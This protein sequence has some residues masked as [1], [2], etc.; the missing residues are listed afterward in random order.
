MKSSPDQRIL[1]IDDMPSI[2]ED[3]RKVL[4]PQVALDEDEE[5]LFGH[6]A[7]SDTGGNYEL[8]SAYQGREGAALA[9]TAVGAGRPYALAFVDMRMPPG[10]D[11]IETIERLWQIDPRLQVVICTAY[12]DHP[13]E[14][15]LERLDVRDRLLVVKKPFD[16]I[17]VS[18]LARTLTA[19]WQLARQAETQI[20][21]LEQA[22]RERTVALELANR[23]L[24]LHLGV[25]ERMIEELAATTRAAE[26]ANQAK[27]QFLA[28]M[29]HEIRTPMNGVIGLSRLLARTELTTRQRDYSDKIMSSAQHLLGIINDILDFSKVD[30]GML[31]IEQTDF[32]LDGMLENARALLSG[33]SAARNLELVMEVAPDVPPCLVGDSL[34]LNQ[35]LINYA[36]NA[37]KF[38][39]RGRIVISVGVGERSQEDVLLRFAVTDTG[40]GIAPEQIDRLFQSFSQV[41][42]ST[43][44]KFGGTGLGLAICK[45]LAGLMGGEVGVESETGKGSTFWFTARLGIGGAGHRRLNAGVERRAAAPVDPSCS[46]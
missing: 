42:A 37:L 46:V 19:K 20:Q 3:F 6:A 14:E 23:N 44:R 25:Q 8:H 9:E 10:W 17:E 43:T 11:G 30:A 34:R 21:T 4:A 35:V 26:L 18:Q 33:K 32:A 1:L 41:D 45:K 40:V 16:M 38:T 22:V 28:N 39:E 15:M 12:A 24:S 36:S 7:L 27:G 29:S 13:W 31:E 5:A 2:H